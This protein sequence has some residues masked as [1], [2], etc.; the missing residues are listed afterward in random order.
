MTPIKRPSRASDRKSNPFVPKP[1]TGRYGLL[2]GFSDG[3]K[4]IVGLEY[5]EVGF[6][7]NLSTAPTRPAGAE[8]AA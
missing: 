2:W 8:G 4:G 6:S 5:P 3:V 7:E 1:R